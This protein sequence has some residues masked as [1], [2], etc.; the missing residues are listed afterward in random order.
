MSDTST[1]RMP[2]LPANVFLPLDFSA[3]GTAVLCSIVTLILSDWKGAIAAFVAGLASWMH[4]RLLL[5]TL[6]HM[7]PGN[8]YIHLLWV[9]IRLALLG[10]VVVGLLILIPGYSLAVIA[11]LVTSALAG[12]L[13]IIVS[14]MRVNKNA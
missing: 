14:L 9:L 8:L 7:Q 13:G 4:L 10:G 1:G 2:K 5:A 3:V 11:G 12:L 6:G